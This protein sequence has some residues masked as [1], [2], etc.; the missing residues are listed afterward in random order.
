M[1]L[2]HNE[3][4]FSSLLTVVA[5]KWLVQ[6]ERIVHHYLEEHVVSFRVRTALRQELSRPDF[7]CRKPPDVGMINVRKAPVPRVQ[8]VQAHFCRVCF[9]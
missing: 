7:Q 1:S 6:V 5:R 8:S 4:E 9:W 2:C 3:F